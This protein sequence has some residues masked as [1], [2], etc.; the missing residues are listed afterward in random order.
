MRERAAARDCAEPIG[1]SAGFIIGPDRL[2]APEQNA[3]PLPLPR[4]CE[5]PASPVW[6]FPATV[7][8][9]VR[10][11]RVLLPLWLC[12]GPGLGAQPIPRNGSPHCYGSLRVLPTARAQRPATPENQGKAHQSRG[13]RCNGQQTRLLA[14]SAAF[15]HLRLSSAVALTADAW[16]L[17]GG[18]R[19]ARSPPVLS[20]HALEQAIQAHLFAAVNPLSCGIDLLYAWTAATTALVV[21]STSPA[22]SIIRSSAARMF[23]CRLGN[24][25]KAWAWR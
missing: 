23:R 17:L 11:L 1:K 25:P 24:R 19:V 2:P 16:N 7:P 12:G 14:I 22:R 20:G 4:P 3:P 18:C 21:T 8:S 15:F 5:P 9:S 13:E 6:G 10:A